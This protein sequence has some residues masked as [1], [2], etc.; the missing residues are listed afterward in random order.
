MLEKI[1]LLEIGFSNV[2][3]EEVLEY[4]VK[5]LKKSSKKYYVVTPNPEILVIASNDEFYT[6]VLNS[7]KIALAD[8]AGVVWA[9]KF[10]GK[11]LKHRITGVDLLEKLCEGVAEKPITVGFLG[12]GPKIAETTAECLKGKY[13][14][15]KVAFMPGY[16][17][18]KLS[19]VVS[20]ILG[21]P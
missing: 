16:F 7:A 19:A 18:F 15:L 9:S 11:P 17:P 2:T 21:P 6:K 13:P 10:L 4:I 1:N 8:G 14:G 12:G 3:P 5:S 20:A